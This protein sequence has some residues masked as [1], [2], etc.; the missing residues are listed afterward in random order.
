MLSG[1]IRAKPLVR[2]VTSLTLGSLLLKGSQ[3]VLIRITRVTA[4]GITEVS[5]DGNT[6]NNHNLY[7]FSFGN[8]KS[9]L[10]FE[11]FSMREDTCRLWNIYGR[12]ICWIFID[13]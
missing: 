1:S 6:K 4:S 10:A 7:L 9:Y 12:Y 8:E 11:D 2:W 3:D 5:T 13:L